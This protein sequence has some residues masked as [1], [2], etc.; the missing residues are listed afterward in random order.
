MIRT[1]V[2]MLFWITTLGVFDIELW[3]EDGLHIKLVGW[4][5]AIARWMGGKRG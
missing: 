3:F 2:V 4:V 1:A 5:G